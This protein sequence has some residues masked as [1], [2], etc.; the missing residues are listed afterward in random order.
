MKR[1]KRLKRH[2][3]KRFS[4]F[5]I[6][7]GSAKRTANGTVKRA[8]NELNYR[9]HVEGHARLLV[10]RNYLVTLF[11]L[12]VINTIKPEFKEQI[13]RMHYITL[14]DSRRIKESLFWTKHE[15]FVVQYDLVRGFVKKST[16]FY[17]RDDV[18]RAWETG[19]LHW[20]E[21]VST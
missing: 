8:W 3:L 19:S 14:L 7:T 5:V 4:A 18:M 12:D 6:N 10:T 13:E 21:F 11:G 2:H 1:G 15:Y 20:I 17:S 16:T 9:G